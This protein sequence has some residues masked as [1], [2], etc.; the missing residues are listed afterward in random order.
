MEFEDKKT[1]NKT[2]N[3]LSENVERNLEYYFGTNIDSFYNSGREIYFETRYEDLFVILDGLKNKPDFDFN[4]L[5]SI[6]YKEAGNFL[7]ISLFSF[8][9]TISINI[10]V[11]N[12]ISFSGLDIKNLIISLKKLFENASYFSDRDYLKDINNDAVIFSQTPE[13]LDT[14]D[15]YLSL[16]DN[17][18]KDIYLCDEISR[19]NSRIIYDGN[20][21]NKLISMVNNLNYKA[22]IY[23]E[24]CFCLG[25]ESLLQ[26]KPPKRS[27]YIRMLLCE[28]FRI[29]CHLSYIADMS[30]V[31]GNM[32]AFNY[33]LTDKEKILNSMEFITGSRTIPNFIR[34]GG[35][36]KDI[37]ENVLEW[38]FKLIPQA[39]KNIKRIEDLFSSDA[40]MLE[41][42][43][44]SGTANSKA[45]KESCV[46][47]PNL[48]A[49]GVR[50]DLRKTANYLLYKDIAFTI[51]LGRVGDSFDRVLIRFKEIYQSLKIINEIIETMPLGATSKMIN[52]LNL[53]LYPA[54][55]ISAVE[56]PFGIFK[57]YI[58]I[59]EN[60]TIEIIPVGSTKNN[61]ILCE[62][63]LRGCSFD[64][65]L[66]VV[67][68]FA[69]ESPEMY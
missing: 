58:D 41:K 52:P 61:I 25:I 51:P 14:F 39:Y 15:I 24:L 45:A 4:I 53:E 29:N 18:I 49:S 23:P 31:L 17:I 8:E 50:F 46:T 32:A 22:G 64:E 60:R 48:R 2:A 57:L 34:V 26:I 16:N 7:L 42:L 3:N 68:S 36:K 44:N 37:E 19:Y 43:R 35:V 33:T 38:I 62:K 56:S 28:L 55:I 12:S 63:T 9:K 54:R 27:T 21:I 11:K 47:G 20:E 65:L 67:S 40:I 6:K 30:L 66:P 69:I 1:K 10:K 5:S 13:T 59:K